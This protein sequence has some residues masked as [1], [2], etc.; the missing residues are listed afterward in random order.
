MIDDNSIL[1]TVKK[2]L[3]LAADYTAFDTDVMVMINSALA[4]L[5]QVTNGVFYP[6]TGS[7]ETWDMITVSNETSREMVKL[8]VY[9]RV[10]Y[11]FDP[12]QISF[13]LNSIS[14]QIRECEWR[15]E[16]ESHPISL[17]TPGGEV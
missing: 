2:L 14:E 17:I 3:G 8:Y 5:A 11:T 15:L 7:E 1:N 10:R 12:P 13:V 16:V 4:T 6:I 9:L